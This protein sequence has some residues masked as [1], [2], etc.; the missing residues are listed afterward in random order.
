MSDETNHCWR[1][2]YDISISTVRWANGICNLNYMNVK[3]FSF[4]ATFGVELTQKALAL[5]FCY[6]YGQEMTSVIKNY[7]SIDEKVASFGQTMVQTSILMGFVFVNGTIFLYGHIFFHLYKT[8]KLN[9]CGKFKST[10]FLKHF[11]NF[12][13]M[14]Y[15]F[16]H[17]LVQWHHQIKN[18]N[19]RNHHGGASCGIFNWLHLCNS[20]FCIIFGLRAIWTS[21][22]DICSNLHSCYHIFHSIHYLSRIKKI[23]LLKWNICQIFSKLSFTY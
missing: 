7:N 11:M 21:S 6:G 8:N 16:S 1:G 2:G 3:L 22:N 12:L 14:R 23:L 18:E 4:E 19:K 13:K 9:K 15:S 10:L 17:R 20:A 5:D